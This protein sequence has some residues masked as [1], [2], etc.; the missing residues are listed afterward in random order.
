MASIPGYF[1]VSRF[2]SRFGGDE[3]PVP[4]NQEVSL[5][6]MEK[7]VFG[8]YASDMAGGIGIFTRFFPQEPGKGAAPRPSGVPQTRVGGWVV[9]VLA[10][11]R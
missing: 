8:D 5:N 6:S 9:V 4:E 1:P 10:D 11:E 7:L 2:G 3:F